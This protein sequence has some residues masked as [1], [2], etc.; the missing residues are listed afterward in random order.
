M[1]YAEGYQL[2]GRDAWDHL[3]AFSGGCDLDVP[4]DIANASGQALAARIGKEAAKKLIAYAGGDRIYIAANWE[5]V[6]ALRYQAIV[7]L[8]DQ[9]MSPEEI[10]VT[11]EFKARYTARNIRGILSGRFELLCNSLGLK[12][13]ELPGV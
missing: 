10:A 3:V 8:H 9:G 4:T 5:R 11:Y 7:A 1:N 2:V 13:Y 6:L 12:Q